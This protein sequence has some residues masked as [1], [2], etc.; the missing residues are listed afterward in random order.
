MGRSST[1]YKKKWSTNW[2][3]LSFVDKNVG[4]VFTA[5]KRFYFIFFIL[6]IIFL[7]GFMHTSKLTAA[8][9]DLNSK[10]FYAVEQ[11]NLDKVKELIRNGAD[12]HAREISSKK[13]IHI[14]VKKG[15]KNI[16]EFFLNEGISVNDTNNSGW[17]PLHYGAF[18][19][20][21]EIA[22][23]L[24]ANGANVRA[25]NAY[26]QKPIDL[27]HY[28][29]D[30]GY[31][32]IMELLLN[33]GGGKVNDI[34]KEGWTLLHYAAFNGNLETV[35]FLIDKG[36]SIHTKNN[37]RETPL[38][39]AREGGSTEV[40]NMLSSINTKVTDVSVSQLSIPRKRTV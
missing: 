9:K 22:K 3:V 12:I 30:D 35:K 7:G 18:G 1:I 24:V 21:L 2:I 8:E 29:K 25:E 31:K 34:D 38:D 23:L 13:A 36:A 6:I 14:A 40:V 26:G 37:G 10:L 17:T 33:K 15:N 28:G 32:G 19:G 4:M 5:S 20:E 27:I 39:L 11:N 16:V